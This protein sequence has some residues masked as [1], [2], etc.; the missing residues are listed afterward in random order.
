MRR[1]LESLHLEKLMHR[2]LE[3]AHANVGPGSPSPGGDGGGDGGGTVG[4]DPQAAREVAK[5]QAA[6]LRREQVRSLVHMT[7]SSELLK[8]SV[9]F[10][11]AL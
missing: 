7:L 4:G 1:Q 9:S 8:L 6:L 3:N 5:A 10:R 2:A 11:R